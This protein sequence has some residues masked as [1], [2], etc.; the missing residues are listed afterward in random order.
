MRIDGSIYWLTYLQA[1]C[2][3]YHPI[4]KQNR[5]NHKE[6]SPFERYPIHCEFDED[7]SSGHNMIDVV[8]VDFEVSELGLVH[9]RVEH[10]PEEEHDQI[11]EDEGRFERKNRPLPQLPW[12][13]R[14]V[15]KNVV[16]TTL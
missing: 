9:G 8:H 6:V 1:Y 12:R 2:Y 15:I 16:V 5:N 10:S 3:I 11:L 14:F 13:M 4:E 7:Y